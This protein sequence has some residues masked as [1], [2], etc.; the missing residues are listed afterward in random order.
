ME[1][2]IM[3]S[4]PYFTQ[5]AKSNAKFL[6]AFTFVLC[7]F[8]TVMCYVF[9]PSAMEGLHAA[10]EGTIA[11]KILDGNGTLI[12]FMANSF[13]ALMAIIFPMVYSIMVGNRLI[14]EKIDKGSMT[15]FLSTPTTR[16]QI[17]MTSAIYFV[18]SLTL[19]WTIATGVGIIAANQF[20]PDALDVETFLLMNVGALLYHIVLSSICFCASCVFNNSKNSLTFG[21]GIPLFFFVIG[22]FIKLSEDLDFLKYVTLNTLFN[23][24]HILAG[25]DYGWE[26]VTMGL[27]ALVLYGTGIVWFNKKD[28][29][30]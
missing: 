15:G 12:G 28:L 29:P 4:L 7:V 18:L 17:T 14:A 13:Y 9:T 3:F 19:M 27:I 16:L 21:A 8:L 24:Q 1:E 10:T 2:M 5:T 25:K 22:L 23:T 11:S 30:L 26:F 20:Q 6:G